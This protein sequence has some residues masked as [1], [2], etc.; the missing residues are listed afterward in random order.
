M[1]VRLAGFEPA[2]CGLEIR[3]SIQL[4]YKRESESYGLQL[5]IVIANATTKQITIKPIAGKKIFRPI[6]KPATTN[7]TQP[8]R[9][10]IIE[11]SILI[12]ILSWLLT[13]DFGILIWI[14]NQNSWNFPRALREKTHVKKSHANA[15]AYA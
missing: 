2:T 7:A 12:N 3:C 8:I 14:S 13:M 15:R 4:S 6:P 5:A 11:K 9:I 1:N 10:R